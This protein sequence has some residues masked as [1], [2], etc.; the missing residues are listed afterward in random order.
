VCIYVIGLTPT[1]PPR[2]RDAAGAS[3]LTDSV[4][5]DGIYE[6]INNISVYIFIGVGGRKSI[7]TSK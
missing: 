2:K 1:R 3:E 6:H 7:Y 5:L 4:S